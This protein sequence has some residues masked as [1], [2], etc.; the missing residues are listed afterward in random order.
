MDNTLISEIRNIIGEDTTELGKWSLNYLN[1]HKE[2]YLEQLDYIS[3]ISGVKRVLEIGG[4]PFHMSMLLKNKGFDLSIIDIAPERFSSF[5]Q[6]NNL[7]VTKLDIEQEE[8]PNFEHKF[9]LIL[10]TEVFEHLRINPLQTLQKINVLLADGGKFL[11]TTP[12]FYRYHNIMTFLTKRGIANAFYE[13]NKLNTIGH[14]GHV[15]EYTKE[16]VNLFLTHSGFELVDFKFKRNAHVPL[17]T[18]KGIV[19]RL[20]NGT[21]SHMLFLSEKKAK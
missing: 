17:L 20:F 18:K 12:N 9:D 3:S 2:R 5:I 15:R 6:N 10:L 16:E 8:F 19:T 21:K 4:A 11:L 1:I 7:D 14:M 13:F